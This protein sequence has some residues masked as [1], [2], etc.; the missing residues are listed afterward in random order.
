MELKE[1]SIAFKRAAGFGVETV[2]SRP[3]YLPPPA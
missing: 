3:S 1:A 2:N